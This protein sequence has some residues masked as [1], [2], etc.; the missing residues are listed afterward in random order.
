MGDPQPSEQKQYFAAAIM[1]S[2]MN[3]SVS[4]WT[5]ECPK[6]WDRFLWVVQ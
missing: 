2:D 4:K 5:F 3:A 6:V 1:L